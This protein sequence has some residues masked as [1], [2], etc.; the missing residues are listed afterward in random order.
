MTLKGSCD[1]VRQFFG[2]S[3][4][5]IL[6]QRGIYPRSSFKRVQKYGIPIFVADDPEL[7]T[8]LQKYMNQV[9]VWLETQK[10]SKLNLVISSVDTNTPIEMWSFA[11]HVEDEENQNPD[12]QSQVDRS[13][14]KKN[15]QAIIRQI[16][17]SVTY[18]PLIESHVKFDLLAY[19]DQGVE[20]PAE[21]EETEEVV[22]ENAEEV[23]LRTLDTSIHK[24]HTKV[25]YKVDAF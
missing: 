24:V 8:F 18:L 4:C 23:G 5:S 6:D 14:I 20:V 15:I 16:C 25:Q 10:L 11:V 21:W 7:V 1:I 12:N 17:A 3:I 2:D 13:A 9:K 22:I 19:T